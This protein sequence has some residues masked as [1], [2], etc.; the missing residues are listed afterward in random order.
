[1]VLLSTVVYV[2][3]SRLTS[4]VSDL[5]YREIEFNRDSLLKTTSLFLILSVFVFV[6]PF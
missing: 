5:W 4:G 6:S 1:M 3:F 2:S